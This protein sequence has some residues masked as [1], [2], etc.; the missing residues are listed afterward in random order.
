MTDKKIGVGKLAWEK[1]KT[2]LVA[3]RKKLRGTVKWLY[4]GL[5]VKRYLLLTLL[6]LL[7]FMGGLFFF[8]RRGLVYRAKVELLLHL[9]DGFFHQPLWGVLL[10]LA[11]A[12]LVLRGLQQTG[13]AI[14]GILLPDH[15]RHLIE[16]LYTRRYLERGPKIVVI[17]GGTGLSVLIRGLKE[18]TSNITAVVTVTDD[19]GSSGRLRGEM[20]VLPPGDLRDCLLALA[21]TEPLLEKLFQYRFPDGKGLGGHN[22]GNLFIV[23]M[24][25]M[26][27]YSRAMQ[28]FSKVL[29]IRGTVLPVTLEQ[30]ILR[31]V[32]TDGSTAVGETNIVQ[33]G[34]HIASLSLQPAACRP[35]PQVL[36]AISEAEA[37]IL[38]PGSLY[39]S[40]LPNLLVPGVKEAL[41]QA[42]APCI[43]VCNIMTQPGETE[44]LSAAGHLQV[45]FRHGCEGL[46]D[47]IVVNNATDLP[48]A[49]AVRY[50]Q[51][52]ATTVKVDDDVLTQWN[53]KVIAAPLLNHHTAAHHDCK[54]LAAL[55]FD[56][57]AGWETGLDGLWAYTRANLNGNL[58][59]ARK[60]MGVPSAGPLAKTHKK[61]KHILKH[62][63]RKV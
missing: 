34:R 16:K 41:A 28:E 3:W 61:L 57:L 22:F 4:P 19:G 60:E 33:A 52:G 36:R 13:K 26:L 35:L 47:G 2:V 43:Y 20:G 8:W 59:R 25:E 50:Q 5:G 62:A 9:M 17:G 23:V 24:A 6:G 10:L 31:A 11:G 21:D 7:I 1:L 14:A 63:L 15:S 58:R 51:E 48:P 45:L 30:V 27:G 54:K 40:V 32:F 42:T 38:G 18:Y 37:I 39:T 53:I 44:G 46:I 55:L 56:R 12:L 29:A 49:L